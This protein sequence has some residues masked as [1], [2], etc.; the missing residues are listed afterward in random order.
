MLVIEIK[1][2]SNGS[3]RN[4]TV[5]STYIPE[6]WAVIPDNVACANFPFGNAEITDVNG[7]PTVTKWIPGKIPD[8]KPVPAPP[9]QLD[10]IMAQVVHTA[11]K[12]GSLLPAMKEVMGRG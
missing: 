8:V 9:S 7:V 11:I 6:G 1:S 10:I 12:S 2:L 3:H 5:D 4:Q